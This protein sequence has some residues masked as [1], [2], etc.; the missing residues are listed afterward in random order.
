MNVTLLLF[1][2]SVLVVIAL[3]MWAVRPAPVTFKSVGELF[4][5]LSTPRHYYR[6]PQILVALKDEDT[7]FL[8]A[9]GLPKLARRLRVERR[10]I[11]LQFLDLVEIDYKT[12]L[13]AARM[14]TAMAPEV[15][16]G[17]EWRRLE[18]SLRFSWNC[19]AL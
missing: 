13:E 14:L 16:P 6:L 8:V 15:L 4:D 10:K 5:A 17:E 18:S 3:L 9:R 1:V 19:M 11:A 2:L 7:E 12:L